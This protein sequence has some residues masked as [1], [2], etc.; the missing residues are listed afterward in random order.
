MPTQLR[1]Y[2]LSPL[3]KIIDPIKLLRWKL[4]LAKVRGKL[5]FSMIKFPQKQFYR[6]NDAALSTDVKVVTSKYAWN[7][8]QPFQDIL[9]NLIW[10]QSDPEYLRLRSEKFVFALRHIACHKIDA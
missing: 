3:P 6:V 10:H 8:H 7:R 2:Y 9:H 1:A 4:D 5:K